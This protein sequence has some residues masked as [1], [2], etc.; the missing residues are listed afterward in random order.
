MRIE[1]VEVGKEYRIRQWE[2]MANEFGID[3]QGNIKC[4]FSF[5]KKMKEL[6]GKTGKELTEAVGQLPQI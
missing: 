1:D 2:D 3:T 6:C 5:V 4:E